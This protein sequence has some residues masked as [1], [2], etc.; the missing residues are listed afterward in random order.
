[1]AQPRQLDRAKPRDVSGRRENTEASPLA[2]AATSI[3][4]QILNH[5]LA[6]VRSGAF[7]V[8]YWDGFTATYGQEEPAFTLRL[9]REPSIGSASDISLWFGEAYMNGDVDVSG[10]LADLVSVANANRDLES[11]WITGGILRAAGALMPEGRRSHERQREQVAHHYDIGNAFFRLWLDE[12]MTYS[13]AY[14]HSPGDS[15]EQAQQQ[16]IDLSLRKL[17]IRPG[18][19]L[20]DIGCGWGALIMRAA[21]DYGATCL[22]ITLS[23][24]QAA[25][26]RD[27]IDRLGLQDVADVRLAHYESLA[28]ENAQFDRIVSIGMIEHVGKPHLPDFIASVDS[29]LKPGGIALLHQITSPVEGAIDPWIE[30]YIFP[31]AYLPTVPELTRLLTDRGF[32]ILGIENLRPHYAMTLNHWSE[33]FERSAGEVRRMFDE[34]FVR[35]WR[36]YLRGTSSSF[37]DG[38]IEVH[39]ILVS[40]GVASGLPLTFEDVYAPCGRQEQQELE[41]VDEKRG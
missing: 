38:Q 3:K 13:C 27:R 17:R 28:R 34:R 19:R 16:K 11:D 1:M 20:L 25:G 23:E 10:D 37:R 7:A 41:K 8:E 36:L 32:R 22:G 31:G 33:R 14:F 40:K 6:R 18:D 9:R 12:S 15:L 4:R 39:Q 5:I 21:R 30:R 35:M 26:A 24:E 29:M 2:A